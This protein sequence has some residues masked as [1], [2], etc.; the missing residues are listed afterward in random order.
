MHN[1]IGIAIGNGQAF[2]MPY[3]LVG[4]ILALAL[5]GAWSLKKR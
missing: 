5:I 2:S 4:A 1:N 3:W